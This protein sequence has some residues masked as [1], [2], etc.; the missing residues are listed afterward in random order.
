MQ[1]Q[2][3]RS[4]AHERSR[5]RR[6]GRRADSGLCRG[7]TLLELVLVIVLLG[8][9]AAMAY[10]SSSGAKPSQNS[11]DIDV[12]KDALRETQLRAMGDL[13][14][15]NWSVNATAT[16]I[17][18]YRSGTQSAS[19][20]LSGSTGSFAASFNTLGQLQTNQSIPDSIAIDSETGYIP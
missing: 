8:I 2:P 5:R 14:T 4:N 19:Y 11:S 18:I 10:T 3:P 6:D 9:L 1:E 13:S 15:A 16:Q 17:S 20:P 7:F 12:I